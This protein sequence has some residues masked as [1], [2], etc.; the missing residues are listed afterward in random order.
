MTCEECLHKSICY[1]VDS[2]QSDYARKC[3]DFISGWIPVTEDMPEESEDAV[4]RQAVHRQINKWV[5]SGDS[6]KNL[7]S[8]H[9]R[10]DDLPPVTQKYGKWK[11]EEFPNFTSWFCDKCG[12]GWRHKFNYC[13]NCGDKKDGEEENK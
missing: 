10:V 6:D 3:G 9:K 1:R 2:V 11:R 5:A 4:S 8:L 13:P 7:L 12:R